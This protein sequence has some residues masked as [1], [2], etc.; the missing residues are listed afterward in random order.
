MNESRAT[1]LDMGSLGIVS[2]MRLALKKVCVHG[3]GKMPG[4]TET[5]EYASVPDFGDLVLGG[6]YIVEGSL[7]H[8]ETGE[9]IGGMLV[10]LILPTRKRYCVHSDATG[11]FKIVAISDP[12]IG[13][14]RPYKV[15]VDFGR[16]V[17]APEEDD[18]IVLFGDFT[19][20]FRRT[21]PELECLSLDVSKFDGETIY[22]GKDG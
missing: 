4:C 7:V 12:K 17:A 5:C 20:T 16:M 9:A 22:Q 13:D 18:Q 6:E 14:R 19:N 1:L 10:S 2:C 8:F 3:S 21:H 11:R 15:A